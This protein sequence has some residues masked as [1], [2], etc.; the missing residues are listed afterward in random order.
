MKQGKSLGT[1]HLAHLGFGSFSKTRAHFSV[2]SSLRFWFGSPQE[3]GS[4]ILVFITLAIAMYSVDQAKWITPQP[5]LTLVLGI[6]VLTSLVLVRR[7]LPN[8]ATFSLMMVLGAVTTIW[9]SSS[10]LVSP[11]AT[12]KSNHL[13]FALYSWW[14]A[15]STSQPN[16]G[17]VHFA[18]FLLLFT[19]ILGF[20]SIWFI[21]RKQNAWIAV[22]LGTMII[23]LNLSNLPK[24]HYY[25]FPIY[26]L[27][28]ML[29]IGQTNFTKQS[30][31][32]KRH[33]SN[34]PTHATV[35]FM[36]S[37][38]CISALTVSSAWFV[39]ET[40]L[41]Q[42][43]STINTEIPQLKDARAHWF[44]IFAAVPSKWRILRSIEQENLTF[45]DPPNLSDEIQFVITPQQ[46]YHY[47]RTRRY[48]TYHS[49]GWTSNTDSNYMLNPGT[50]ANEGKTFPNH[51]ELNYTVENKL[52]TDVLLTAGEFISSNIPV[53]VK[54]LSEKGIDE[55]SSS[56]DTAFVVPPSRVS[57]IMNMSFGLDDGG[58]FLSRD[59]MLTSVVSNHNLP[60]ETDSG[61]IAHTSQPATDKINYV[62]S[63]GA[64]DIIS[65]IAPQLL[66]PYQ[67]YTVA[68]SIN[69]ATPT[70]LSQAG[71]D[72]DGWVTEHYLQLPY[73][74]P[75]LVR[76]LSQKIVSGAETPYDKVVAVKRFL[77]NF[78]Y[79]DAAKAPPRGSDGV[80]Y[81]LFVQREGACTN[82]ASAMVILLRSADVPTRLCTGYFQNETAKNTG[83]I[84]IRAQDYHA[85][86][87]VYFPG[88]GW[89]EFEATPISA[90]EEDIL[91]LGGGDSDIYDWLDDEDEEL[92]GFG[93]TSQGTTSTI[94]P[95]QNISYAIA[96]IL[97]LLVFALGL[98]LYRWL[99]RFKRVEAAAEVYYKMCRL[100]LLTKSGPNAYETPLE[101][102][103]RLAYTLPLQAEAVGS[104]AQAYMECQFSQRKTLGVMQ[105]TMLR[106]S[107]HAVY[108]ALLKRML[109]LKR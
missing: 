93:P 62:A 108:R 85:W 13:M 98:V 39:P 24:E 58:Q 9:Q 61:L 59:K 46:P 35:Y 38:I 11:E 89:V 37:V 8:A 73:S 94:R 60:T 34:Y 1:A 55:N 63:S 87:E 5:P 76:Q 21:L 25:F 12:V 30:N 66:K 44:N 77:R 53:M 28:A 51:Q 107:W 84:I 90:N 86:P 23:A 42:P 20:I 88:Y 56:I 69:P 18:T 95:R 43:R 52:K 47:W 96:S 102:C 57:R 92:A 6:A 49:W 31:W 27:A 103:T 75:T 105:K 54:T 41:N 100:A 78:K 67:R 50:P 79:N 101:Y 15:I 83:K 10:L 65:V 97:F 48:D 4:A 22:S 26:L 45:R 74:L 16:E 33:G 104:I 40:Q 3:W 70:E 17:T 99:Q 32:F 91:D 82:F 19:W 29:L 80:Y 81:F 109:R 14:Q 36:T 68:A 106:K 7:R 72:Y 64:E 2:R 71:D